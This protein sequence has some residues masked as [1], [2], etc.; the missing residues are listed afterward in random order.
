[1][2]PNTAFPVHESPQNAI[3]QRIL[4]H[5]RVTFDVGKDVLVLAMKDELLVRKSIRADTHGSRLNEELSKIARN[6]GSLGEGTRHSKDRPDT[7]LPDDIEIWHLT[8]PNDN[9]IDQARRLLKLTETKDVAALGGHSAVA[10][11]VSPNHICVVSRPFDC[12]P[13]GPPLP[14]PPPPPAVLGAY[15][16]PPQKGPTAR[17]VVIDTGYIET[18]PPYAAL[19]HR[20]TAVP[21]Q[22][23]D[24]STVPATWRDDPPDVLDADHDGRLDGVAG[25]GTFIAG[26]VAHHARQAE[27]T[28]VGQRHECM[29]LSDPPDPV[30]QARLFTTEFAVAHSLLR[31]AEADVDV[32]SCGFAFPTLDDRPSI[33]FASVMQ[34]LSGP[35]APRRGVAVVAPA[36]NERSDRPF[37]P[38][39]LSDVIGVAATNRRGGARAIFSNWGPWADCCARGADVRSTYVDWVGPIEGEPP[40]EI[41]NFV[42]WALWDGTSFSAPKVSAAIAALV[43]KSGG[44][45]LPVDA[46][47]R[48]ISGAGGVVVTPLTDTTLSGF[49]GVML[50]HLHLG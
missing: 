28:V 48:L 43:A 14:T 39:A 31:H 15:V 26:I 40:T 6:S 1:V 33:P 10:P 2:S 5:P 30:D 22:W 8:D 7:A 4:E 41:D 34:V 12:C 42:G 23:L 37:W 44:A 3:T 35:E 13:A 19:D 27:I 36:G 9:S 32:V 18:D 21:G 16:Q 45:L 20:V 17:V 47:Q 25:H 46:F 11:A 50:P 29:P 49:P 24:T 38:A